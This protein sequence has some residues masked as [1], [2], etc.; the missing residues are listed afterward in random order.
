MRILSRYVFREIL[1]SSLLGTALATFVVFL[2]GPGKLLLEVLVRTSATPAVGLKLFILALPQVL[3]LTIPF[4]VLVGIL[5]GLGRMASDGEIT[6][7]RAGGV[8]SRTV[9]PPVITFCLL[10][11][12]IA[13]TASLWL[14][15]LALRSNLK[16]VNQL[17]AEQLTADIQP[18]VFDESF[19]KKVLYVGNVK[20]GSPTVWEQVFVAD[21]TPPE[22]RPQTG[23]KPMEGPQVTIAQAAIPLPDIKRNRIQL[24][25]RN[26]SVHETAKDGQGYHSAFPTGEQI[27][28][29]TQQAEVKAR[30]FREMPTREL[31]KFVK[32]S[33]PKSDDGATARVELY[34]R[35][36]L[37]LACLMLGLVGVPLGVQSRKGGKS[38]G[39]ITAILLAFLC[40]YLSFITLT[41]MA[42]KH[43]ISPELGT[44]LPNL[45]FGIAGAIMIARLELPGDTDVMGALRILFSS[46]VDLVRKKRDGAS[47]PRVAVRSTGARYHLFQIIDIYVLAEFL[48]YFVLWLASF[49]VMAVIYNFFELLSDIIK[50]QIPLSKVFTYL[51]FLTPKLIYDTLP[52]SVLVAVLVTFG[53]LTKNNE[54]TAFKACGVSVRR[55][56]MPVLVMSLVLSGALFAFDFFYVPEANTKQDALRNEIKGRPVQTYLRKDQKWIYGNGPR[57]F[58]YRLFDTNQNMMVGVN[59]YELDP[60]TF[61]L[62]KVISAERAQWQPAMQKWI[63]QDGWNRELKGTI[64]SKFDAFQATTFPELNEGPNWFIHEVKQDKQMNY[65]ELQSYIADLQKRGFDTVQLRVQL[66]KKFSV[67]LFAFI[68]AM[69][70]VPFGFLVGNRGAMAGIGVSIAIA[71]AYWGIDKFFEQIGNVNHLPA[72]VAAWAPDALFGLAG[73]YLL[74][75]MRS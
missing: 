32:T 44:W 38:A 17:Y 51:F 6:A 56:G 1:S 18:R 46:L 68:M 12:S 26:G 11:T 57:I 16:I 23:G 43:T 70:S 64:E 35:L 67:P 60:K 69:I 27:L 50:N 4:G 42:R 29:A 74:L 30:A 36:A 71:M 33:D 10:A 19:P 5:I 9:T 2:Q 8:S 15:P 61:A 31:Y 22:E 72:T 75:R 39:Y 24:T 48:F 59:V 37:P 7:M 3:P 25:M 21:L 66:Y 65:L 14:T 47:A 63:F 62:R 40:Y 54:V 41:S 45:I 34:S 55:L 58:Y 13:G 73:A 52:V 28:E 53:I 49:V 20:T